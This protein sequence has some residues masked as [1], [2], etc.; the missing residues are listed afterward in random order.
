MITFML[1]LIYILTIS[2]ESINARTSTNVGICYGRLGNNLPSFS[3]SIQLIKS[4]NAS[5]VKI[6]DANLDLLH[7]LS[8]TRLHV[9]IMI[10]N[11]EIR[12]IASNQTL[13]DEWVQRH[14]IPFYPRTRIQSILVGNE[15]LSDSS[16]LGRLLWPSLVPAMQRIST[17]L[18]TLRGH[19]TRYILVGTPLAMDMLMSTFPPSSGAF[20][21]DIRE[22]VMEPLLNFLNRTRSP[23]FLDVYTYFPWSSDP[24]NIN[25]DYALLAQD[26]NN[27]YTDPISGLT[28][29]NLLDQMMDSV[30]FAMGKLGYHDIKLAIAETGWP[31]SNGRD[32]FGA[33]I[34]NAEIYNHNVIKKM[35]A[36]PPIGTP[37]RPGEAIQTYLFSLY[38][39]NRKTGPEVRGIGD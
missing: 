39:E 11:Q 33:N 2:G 25:L 14:V 35:T 1:Y 4:M 36:N 15:I 17:S 32:G 28:Y 26:K 3:Q 38:D 10:P 5:S 23:F 6:Y 7:I 16:E 30:Y 12:R 19:N 21:P 13:A 24:S 22:S 27:E 31:N 8:G 9:S 20:R 18:R 37:A 29:T 34:Y